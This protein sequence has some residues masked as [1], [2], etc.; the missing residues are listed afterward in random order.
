MTLEFSIKNAPSRIAAVALVAGF[1]A[2]LGRSVLA[3]FIIG[4]LTDQR[5]SVPRAELEAAT[6]YFPGSARLTGKL[7]EVEVMGPDRDLPKAL[8]AAVQ[9]VSLSPNDYGFRLV[10]AAVREASG[11]S[12]GAEQ[13]LRAAADLAPHNADA[14]WRLANLM[15]RQGRLDDSLDSFRTSIEAS[16]A[17]L[18][19]AIDLVWRYSLGDADKVTRIVPDD[20]ASKITLARFLLRQGR[21]T[22]ACAAFRSIDPGAALQHSE[23]S[24]FID[25]LIASEH[26]DL[27]YQIWFGLLGH[28][29]DRSDGNSIWNSGFEQDPALGFDQFDWKVA[30][31]DY[32]EVSIDPAASNSGSRS[33]RVDFEGHDTT[34]LDGNLKQLTIERA[35][36]RYRLEFYAR[37]Q[38]LSTNEGPWIALTSTVFPNWTAKSDPVSAGTAGW[39]KITLDFEAPGAVDSGYVPITVSLVRIPKLNYEQA[40]RGTVWLDDFSLTAAK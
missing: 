25:E 28:D 8:E 3:E 16:P 34:R 7:A 18:P 13:A 12:A 33:L 2:L 20:A 26:I 39:Q 6:H 23:T 40:M 30:H 27:A 24:N 1:C 14:Q 32:A 11:D 9:A 5:V 19:A 4:A 17:L 31:S 29:A 36:V 10:L 15:L 38:D 37:S 22:Q 35:G 21:A